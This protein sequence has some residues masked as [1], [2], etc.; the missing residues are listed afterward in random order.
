MKKRQ[1]L[2]FVVF[3]ILFILTIP[4]FKSIP[5]RFFY[6]FQPVASTAVDIPEKDP[7]YQKIE[8]AAMKLNEPAINAEIDR[9][10]KAIPGYNGKVVDI[11]ASYRKMKKYGFSRE[12]L[13][14][15]ETSPE[16]H[17]SDLPPA[18]IYKGNPHKPMVALMVN[19]AWGNEWIPEMLNIFAEHDVSATF[20]LDGSWTKR[21]PKLARMIAREGHEIGNHAYSHPVMGQ[22]GSAAI[23]EQLTKT[24]TVISSV[25]HIEP[26]LFAPPGGSYNDKCVEIAD[27]LGMKTILWTVDTVDWKHPPP[28]VIIQKV[29]TNIHPG[30]FVLMHPTQNTVAA[31]DDIISGIRERGYRIGTVSRVISEDRL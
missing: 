27:R 29:L 18:P 23:L 15:K 10:W 12:K 21:H 17:L 26:K 1:T 7:L 13:V 19:V 11:E 9:V 28:R 25:L 24:N 22:L 5:G 4:H 6:P 8:Q 20:F 3:F 2:H 16:V 31:L 30:A 14:F